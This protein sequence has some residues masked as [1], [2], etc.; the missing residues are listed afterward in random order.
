MTLHI[1]AYYWQMFLKCG[2]TLD[3]NGS[4]CGN[5]AAIEWHSRYWLEAERT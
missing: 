5:A 2:G 3:A 1:V 4:A